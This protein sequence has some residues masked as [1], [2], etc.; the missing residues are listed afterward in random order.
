MKIHTKIFG[1]IDPDED[2]LIIFENGIVGFPQLKRFALIYDVEKGDKSGIRWLQSIE[3]E[4]FAIPVLDPLFVMPDYNPSVDD[5]LLNPIGEL[6]PEGMLVLVT[7]TVPSDLHK[8][9]VNLKAP[10]IINACT[11]KACQVIAEGDDY[12]VKYYIYD[13]LE[14]IKKAG[15]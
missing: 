1:E 12:S 11:R 9:S 3:D 5:N 13:I 10:I 2:K 8:M 14:A 4:T 15:E 7:L 6:S